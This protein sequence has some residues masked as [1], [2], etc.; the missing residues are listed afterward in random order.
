MST[1]TKITLLIT[2]V[3]VVLAAFGLSVIIRPF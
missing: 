3:T 2:V 1:D